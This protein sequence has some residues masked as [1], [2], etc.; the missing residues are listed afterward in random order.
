MKSYIFGVV[1]NEKLVQF[2]NLSEFYID[3]RKMN[4]KF[5]W[6]AY[7]E[8]V[9]FRVLN[10]IHTNLENQRIPTLL[11]LIIFLR[12]FMLHNKLNYLTANLGSRGP[13][14]SFDDS[15]ILRAFGLIFFCSLHIQ[16]T[17]YYTNQK[18]GTQVFPPVNY[19][20]RYWLTFNT[21][22]DKSNLTEA[23]TLSYLVFRLFSPKNKDLSSTSF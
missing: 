23:I 11:S 15:S 4:C 22:R 3:K 19:R 2:S 17:F 7:L 5:K 12:Y 21:V 1:C 10:K 13:S 8:K 9:H 16:F 6:F 18:I 20:S 14:N